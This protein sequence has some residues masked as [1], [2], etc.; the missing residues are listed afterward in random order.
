MHI[1]L[2]HN[3][4]G[5]LSTD[6]LAT[7]ASSDNT[8]NTT[9]PSDNGNAAAA[10]GAPAGATTLAPAGPAPTGT[11]GLVAGASP[12]PPIRMVFDT[13]QQ[14]STV[15]TFALQQQLGSEDSNAAAYD[16]FSDINSM[17]QG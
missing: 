3:F 15:D 5:S 6:L 11:A 1:L 17:I 14:Q 9:T 10:A 8:T 13:S 16:R 4:T 2:I 12:S 7:F